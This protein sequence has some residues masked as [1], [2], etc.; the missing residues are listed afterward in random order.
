M[1][2]LTEEMTQL[3]EEESKELLKRLRMFQDKLPERQRGVFSGIM[4]GAGAV[5]D[6]RESAGELDEEGASFAKALLTFRDEL[7]PPLRDAFTPVLSA[8]ALG[9]GFAAGRAL[10]EGGGS[11]QGLSPVTYCWHAFLVPAAVI[12]TLTVLI[13]REINKDNPAPEAP[14]LNGIKPSPEEL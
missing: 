6:L 11:G 13:V 2:Q 5:F 4:K 14:N 9:W 7:P 10:C 1:T 3:T 8:G 12:G